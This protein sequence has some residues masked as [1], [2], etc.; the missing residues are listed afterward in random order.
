MPHQ[1]VHQ[2]QLAR[3][4]GDPFANVSSTLITLSLHDKS[5]RY[6]DK[7]LKIERG[8]SCH[9]PLQL[10]LTFSCSWESQAVF[11]VWV[12]QF[13]SCMTFKRF[14]T[15]YLCS[16]IRFSSK[17]KNCESPLHMGRHK[18]EIFKWN[19]SDNSA[20]EQ[21]NLLSDVRTSSGSW[22][23]HHK[24]S[25]FCLCIN[26]YIIWKPHWARIWKTRFSFLSKSNRTGQ[27]GVD[28]SNWPEFD[29]CVSLKK[30]ALNEAQQ[31]NARWQSHS[32]IYF[33]ARPP[34]SV[35]WISRP[36]VMSSWGCTCPSRKRKYSLNF[37]CLLSD[38]FVPWHSWPGTIIWTGE[39]GSAE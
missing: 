1:R 17:V 10:L 16:M 14:H 7:C 21:I 20:I 12:P 19:C 8:R 6:I 39:T 29:W 24:Q 18:S 33:I 23:C 4:N 13:L 35:S 2:D 11:C 37:I 3:S 26:W 34:K 9:Y 27:S 38:P 31:R 25:L 22:V 15:V 36:A 5:Q 32:S 28:L 30:A